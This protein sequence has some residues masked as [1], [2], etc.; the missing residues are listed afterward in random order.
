MFGAIHRPFLL[1]GLKALAFPYTSC[2]LCR[3][4]FRR[5]SP[6]CA[7]PTEDSDSSHLPYFSSLLLTY[8][9][10]LLPTPFTCTFTVFHSQVTQKEWTKKRSSLCTYHLDYHPRSF[11]K[12]ALTMFF[13]D[14]IAVYFDNATSW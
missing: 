6:L 12:S 10:L 3:A 11:G 8:L 5:P 4:W 13:P 9:L 2:Q 1:T 14:L 7:N